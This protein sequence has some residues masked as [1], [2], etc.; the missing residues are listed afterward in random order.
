MDCHETIETRNQS[1]SRADAAEKLGGFFLR[2]VVEWME[3]HSA[4]ENTVWLNKTKVAEH[5]GVTI[6]TLS[7]WLDSGKFPPHERLEGRT[8]LWSLDTVDRWIDSYKG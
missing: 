1:I 6:K 2:W 8:L 3:T 7:S 4:Y 5:V